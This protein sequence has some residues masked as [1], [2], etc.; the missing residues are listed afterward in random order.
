[1]P[2]YSN[3]I[4]TCS[5]NLFSQ[6]L[7][8]S[9]EWFAQATNDEATIRHI[10]NYRE[11]HDDKEKRQLPLVC[12]QAMFTP[13]VN[14]KGVKGLWRENHSAVLTGM[15]MIDIDHVSDAEQMVNQLL[16]REDFQQL[17]ILAVYITPS[18]HGFK[19][20]FKARS[21]WG[22]LID[23]QYEMAAL[24]G[25]SIDIGCK[26]AAR[27]SF[28]PQASDVKFLSDE[29]FTYS[30][31]AYDEQYGELYRQKPS[32][33]Y[34]TQ[35]KWREYE[36]QLREQK[37]QAKRQAAEPAAGVSAEKSAVMPAEGADSAVEPE[38]IAA[39][40][41]E[42]VYR[43]VP[44]SRIVQTLAEQMGLPEKGDRHNT[45]LRIGR[46]MSI[47]CDNDPQ[48][49]ASTMKHLDFVKEIVSER[50]EEEVDQAMRYICEKPSYLFPSEQL[51][52]A[53]RKAGVQDDRRDNCLDTSDLPLSE[54]AD[55]IEAY[56]DY[57]PCLREVCMGV[58]REAWPAALFV[59][60]GFFGTL[61]T[62]CT[63]HYWFQSYK[64]CRL[65]YSMY[66]IG[67]PSSGKSFA[68]TL[69][70]LI[71]APIKE[72]SQRAYEAMN[73]YKRERSAR[74][75]STKAQEKAAL[76]KPTLPCRYAPPRTSN[77]VFIQN[78]LDSKEVV[79]GEEMYLHM[80][81]FD[82]ELA[83]S[84]NM[85][86][87][88]SWIDKS[89][90]ELKA[91]H[92]EEDGQSYGNADSLSGVFSIFWNFIYTGTPDALYKK[93]NE[94]NFGSGQ[95]PRLA[96]IPM[97]APSFSIP[98]EK[99]TIEDIQAAHETISQ[100]SN[101]QNTR[102]GELPVAPIV[103]VCKEWTQERL[104]IAEYNDKDQADQM[105][106]NRA[107]YY[108]VHITAPFIDMRHSKEFDESG[109]YQVD[110]IDC[111]FAQ[112]VLDIQYRCQHHFFGAMAYNYFENL[113]RRTLS[114]VSSHTSTFAEKFEKLPNEFTTEQFASV[115]G[116]ANT[117]SATIQLR[118]LVNEHAIERVKRG[119][120]KRLKSRIA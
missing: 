66:I 37:K 120:Y 21:E 103:A 46:H 51:R 76:K 3:L 113:K 88:G 71:L 9:P 73:E 107:G 86:K 41:P 30:N 77:Q 64:E 98:E 57:Y 26:D 108:G 44:Y 93:V 63:Y 6:Q 117:D 56:M 61:M 15:V 58:P 50:G 23:N 22:N 84:I 116:L 40:E 97:P 33:T 14:K 80:V 90:M 25:L 7:P 59:A 32:K 45:M 94:S 48:L 8:L 17:G 36:K 111:Q 79:D 102:R 85:Q 13:S 110:D 87:G 118:S 70:R 55:R 119:C 16:A 1:M 104:A 96:V 52:Q 68:V 115:Y 28:V 81:T 35:K 20:V 109:T 89:T 2:D 92:N 67:A 69:D 78:M 95:A 12:F 4:A 49:L 24:L 100:W 27:A 18:G 10:S 114:A 74:T 112:L 106:I 75:T 60:A 47:I 101:R 82:S 19:V 65:N 99:E 39:V 72:E 31:P 11:C 43:G 54:W 91:F 53:L 34:P 62:R 5:P 38:S 105:I 83:N 42:S 29:L